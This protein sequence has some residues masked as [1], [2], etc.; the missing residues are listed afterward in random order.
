MTNRREH[1][2]LTSRF[3]PTFAICIGPAD[4]PHYWGKFSARATRLTCSALAAIL[5]AAIAVIA[6]SRTARDSHDRSRPVVLAYFR[7]A[8]HNDRAFDFVV[9]N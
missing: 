5:T 8:E 6:L 4:W 7:A 3:A 9:R 1:R 2:R